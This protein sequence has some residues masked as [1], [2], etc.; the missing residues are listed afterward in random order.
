MAEQGPAEAVEMGMDGLEGILGCYQDVQ[1]WDQESQGVDGIKLGKKCK[2][3][4][5]FIYVHWSQQTVKEE[6]IPSDK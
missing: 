4:E 3:Q 6:C 2:K 1:G 5:G